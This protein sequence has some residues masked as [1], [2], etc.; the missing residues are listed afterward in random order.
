[1]YQLHNLWKTRSHFSQVSISVCSKLLLHFLPRLFPTTL[2]I[3]GFPTSIFLIGNIRLL[4]NMSHIWLQVVLITVWYI[5]RSCLFNLTWLD[6]I[7]Y[8][9]TARKKKACLQQSCYKHSLRENEI[10]ILNRLNVKY[11]ILLIWWYVVNT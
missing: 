2:L 8:L 7:F 6:I 11:E 9:T 3:T 1:M 10:V 4:L 5:L